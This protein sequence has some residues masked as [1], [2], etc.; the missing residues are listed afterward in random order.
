MAEH[1]EGCARGRAPRR[2]DVTAQHRVRHRELR[3]RLGQD[4]L[5]PTGRGLPRKPVSDDYVNAVRARRE[6]HVLSVE[7]VVVENRLVLLLGQQNVEAAAQTG[8]DIVL[9]FADDDQHV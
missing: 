1:V 4:E 7:D 8:E 2:L 3:A 9:A 5:L 6:F